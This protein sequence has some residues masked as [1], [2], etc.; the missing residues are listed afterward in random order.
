MEGIWTS[1]LN[2]LLLEQSTD[3]GFVNSKESK[4][5]FQVFINHFYVVIW[6]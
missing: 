4:E 6:F 1:K 2:S 3:L 5:L